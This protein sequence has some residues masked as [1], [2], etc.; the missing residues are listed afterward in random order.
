MDVGQYI[1]GISG[2]RAFLAHWAETLDFYHKQQLVDEFFNPSTTDNAR[3]NTL[4]QYQVQYILWGP[5]ERSIGSV[6]PDQLPYLIPV[7]TSKT[8]NLYQVIT[9]SNSTHLPITQPSVFKNKG[10]V[11]ELV[12]M[13]H[14]KS[15]FSLKTNDGNCLQ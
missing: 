1:P 15:S 8:V 9:L 5:N 11:H 6:N 4:S 7:F 14:L 12:G 2:R 3:M 13:T 10:R